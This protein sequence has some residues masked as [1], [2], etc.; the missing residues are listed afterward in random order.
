MFDEGIKIEWST[1]HEYIKLNLNELSP[2][3]EITSTIQVWKAGGATQYNVVSEIRCDGE[4]FEILLTYDRDNNTEIENEPGYWGTATI[5][6][7]AGQEEGLA[8]WVGTETKVFDGQDKV[9]KL[10]SGLTGPIQRHTLSRIQREE[11]QQ[12]R[13][14]LLLLDK[15]CAITSES[16]ADVLDAA[17][18][19]AAKR[20]GREII[21][22]AILL[23]ADVHRL[24]DSGAISIK[25]D[26]TVNILK[27]L[28]SGY[29]ELLLNKRLAP[30]V[31]KR[32]S[33]ALE[34]IANAT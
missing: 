28:P 31:H 18:I 32:V 26:G 11:Q 25:M 10:P 3:T 14:A 33:K 13:A 24:L 16:F 5:V 19:I 7:S 22:N 8:T 34:H 17:H 15:V 30:I 12:L 29:Q 4:S 20:G 2:S 9:T 23:R 27:E 21:E 1:G 6:I